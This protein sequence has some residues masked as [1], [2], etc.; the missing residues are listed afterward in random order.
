MELLLTASEASLTVALVTTCLLIAGHTL[1]IAALTGRRQVSHKPWIIAYECL[2][3]VFLVVLAAITYA[4]ASGSHEFVMLLPGLRIP[5]E[6]LL[7]GNLAAAGLGVWILVTTRSRLLA[8]ES[9][10]LLA[11]TPPALQFAGMYALWILA[12]AFTYFVFRVLSAVLIDIRQLAD[13]VAHFSTGDAVMRMPDG[14]LI[15]EATGR[16]LVMNNVMRSC[17]TA[18]SLATDLSEI[19]G[20][21]DALREQSNAEAH[22]P[23]AGGALLTMP[24][25]SV[26]LFTKDTLTIDG[27]A[28][29]RLLAIDVTEEH[30]LNHALAQENE[31]LAQAAGKLRVIYRNGP[32]AAPE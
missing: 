20:L 7:W 28:C 32:E 10:V 12:A 6:P 11:C 18:R 3:L 2:I 15:A 21:W 4:A 19:R 13:E 16:I 29:E 23:L 31:L 27:R 1:H 5:L 30:R 8:V 25:G 9:L 26:R 14:V 22:A 24:E 17:L